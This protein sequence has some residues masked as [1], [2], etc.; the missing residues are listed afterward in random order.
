[1]LYGEAL[2]KHGL[3][4]QFGAR[5]GGSYL[6]FQLLRRQRLGGWSFVARPDKK[7]ARFHLYKKC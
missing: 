1:M 4:F 7:L 5:Y 3:K 2:D 6:E